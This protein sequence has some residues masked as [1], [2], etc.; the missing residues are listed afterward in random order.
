MDELTTKPTLTMQKEVDGIEM[1]VLSTGEACLSGRGLARLCGVAPSAVIQ[2]SLNWRSGKRTGKLAQML[3][4]AG[5]V[6]NS[7]HFLEQGSSYFYSETVSIKVIEYYAFESQKTEQAMASFRK[8]ATAGLRLFVYRALGYDPTAR[9]SDEWQKYHDRVTLVASPMG[10]F[11]VFRELADFCVAAIQSGFPID[12]RSI[13]DISVGT[14]W[15]DHWKKK[16]L[17][18]RLGERVQHEHNYPDYFPQAASN[19][20]P[21]WVYPID[22]LPEFRRW[23]QNVY[24]PSKFP[25]YLSRKIKAGVLPPSTAELLIANVTPPAL[26]SPAH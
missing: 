13:P 4:E 3:S 11:S 21:M 7:L 24:L 18:A 23:L 10:Y 22:A 6:G 1:A 19:P 25:A 17:D 15:A 20:Q 16:K 5:F 26:N 14:T 2:Q 8:L 12:E 9:V